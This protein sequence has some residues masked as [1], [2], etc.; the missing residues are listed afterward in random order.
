M[1][2]LKKIPEST[3]LVRDELQ[4]LSTTNQQLR[5]ELDLLSYRL[6]K[7]NSDTQEIRRD[8][9]E[10]KRTIENLQY[11]LLHELHKNTRPNS[12]NVPSLLT[13]LAIAFPAAMFAMILLFMILVT[14]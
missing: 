6:D 13:T 10:I 11:E 14:N 12:Q 8:V 1:V 3:E 7:L 5:F 9:Y 4:T 2:D